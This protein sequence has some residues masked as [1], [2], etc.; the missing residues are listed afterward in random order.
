MGCKAGVG[1]IP[2][3]RHLRPWGPLGWV[4]GMPWYYANAGQRSGPVGEEEFAALVARGEIRDDTLVWKQG[5]GD[6]K[7]YAEVAALLS[8]PPVLPGTTTNLAPSTS[9]HPAAGGTSVGGVATQALFPPRVFAGFWL[10]FLA[11]LI[12]GAILWFAGQIVGG[13]LIQFALPDALQTMAEMRADPQNVT[14]E[15][16]AVVLQMML[17]VMGLNLVI[18]LIYDLVFLGKYGATPGKM[19]LGLKIERADGSGL[20]LGRITGRYFA[21]ILSGLLLCI[22][23]LIAAFDDQKRALHDYICDTRVVKKPSA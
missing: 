4:R 21:Q 22:G 7:R 20:S 1:W 14:P 9:S 13:I 16:V 12:D 23:Y 19:A 6:W 2:T 5:M 18:G 3:K 17:L 10:R 11:R 15:Q 8:L